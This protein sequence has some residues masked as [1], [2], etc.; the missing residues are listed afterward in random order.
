MPMIKNKNADMT[1]MSD[2]V[3][4]DERMKTEMYRTLLAS[5]QD[6]KGEKTKD[7]FEVLADMKK[8][9]GL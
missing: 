8:K 9:Y 2:A 5:E 4:E 6:F 3:C 1:L 7:G